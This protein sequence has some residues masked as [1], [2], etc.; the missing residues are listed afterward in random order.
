MTITDSTN[1][2][3]DPTV[4]DRIGD[5]L[6]RADQ[7]PDC[8]DCTLLGDVCYQ[9]AAEAIV[10]AMRAQELVVLTPETADEILAHDRA[11]TRRKVAEEIAVAVED[12]WMGG[13]GSGIYER[14]AAL[15]RKH[16]EE[17]K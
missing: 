7:D 4:T 14:L 6:A 10:A 13:E 9:H 11:E 12:D 1:G 3:A 2:F 5:I 8:G 16:R 15:A 17:Q